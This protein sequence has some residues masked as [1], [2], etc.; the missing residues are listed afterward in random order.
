MKSIRITAIPMAMAILGAAPGGG[1]QAAQTTAGAP[2]P[3]APCAR[4][5]FRAFDFW[6]GEW[7]VRTA[8]G[9]LAGHNRIESSQQGCVLIEHW[10]GLSGNTG[11]SI[12]Y[13]DKASGQWVQIWTDA[14]G[15]QIDIRGGPTD[16]G[17][18][19]EGRIHYV[20]NGTSASFRGLWTPLPDGRVRQFFEQSNDGG[21]T[22]EAWFEGFYSR[23]ESGARS[24]RA[25]GNSSG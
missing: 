24:S 15:G 23:V 21:E 5:E 22:W 3:A 19:L 17:M 11:M 12:N 9:K 6:V 10:T 7:E 8:E 4:E 25:S 2:E 18:L 14:G 13:L 16:D 20:A 1:L